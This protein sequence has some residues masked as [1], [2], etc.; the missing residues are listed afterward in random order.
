MADK[1]AR[2]KSPA[3]ATVDR[4]QEDAETAVAGM[5]A[6]EPGGWVDRGPPRPRDPGWRA[7]PSAKIV[8]VEK[9]AMANIDAGPLSSWNGP[10]S[11]PFWQIVSALPEASQKRALLAALEKCAYECVAPS[12]HLIN[13]LRPFLLSPTGAV[14][15]NPLDADKVREAAA[16]AAKH[17]AA[18]PRAI[19][20]ATGIHPNTIVTW[21]KEDRGVYQNFLR[22]DQ[23]RLQ[24][25]D[26]TLETRKAKGADLD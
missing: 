1:P 23:L 25:E 13:L 14:R 18:S 7:S 21:K 4:T 5:L 2:K 6:D 8:T 3:Q 17:P 24:A 11:R 26:G 19:G 9:H 22:E 10:N 15:G 12:E 16:Y 20:K